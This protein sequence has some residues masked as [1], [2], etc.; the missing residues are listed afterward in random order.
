M[1]SE[2]TDRDLEAEKRLN[3]Q[4]ETYIKERQNS[5]AERVAQ[6]KIGAEKPREG[7]NN[8]EKRMI[9]SNENE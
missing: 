3:A 1:A 9:F 4:L 7:Q 6:E 2:N 8:E 5:N